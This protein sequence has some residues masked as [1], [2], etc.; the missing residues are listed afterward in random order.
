MKLKNLI[1]VAFTAAMA[2]WVTSC[3]ETDS[4]EVNVAIAEAISYE[5]NGCSTA[6]FTVNVT[7]ADGANVGNYVVGVINLDDYINDDA[8]FSSAIISQIE[9]MGGSLTKVDNKYV[10]NSSATAN[11]ATA[12]PLTAGEDYVVGVFSVNSSGELNSEVLSTKVSVV[13][14]S[15]TIDVLSVGDVTCSVKIT[16]NNALVDHYYVAVGNSSILNDEYAGD[17][18]A[19]AEAFI[20]DEI[21]VYGTD[22]SIVD[23]MYVFNTNSIIAL[24]ES[25]I[26]TSATEHVV[27]AFGIDADGTI[28]SDVASTTFSTNEL[29]MSDNTFTFLVTDV[30]STGA[31]LQ[32]T[33]SNSDTYYFDPVES[34][35]FSSYTDAEII[36]LI[37][38]S[39]GVYFSDFLSSGWDAFDYTG[40]L[41]SNTYYTPIAFGTNG[42]AAT[43]ELFK[44]EQFYTV[45]SEDDTTP[46]ILPT[47][48]T[49]PDVDFGTLELVAND[50]GSLTMTV[51]PNDKE[52]DYIAFV[53]YSLYFAEFDSYESVILDDL[54]YMQSYSEYYGGDIFEDWEFWTRSGDFTGEVTGFE[55]GYE[56]VGYAY[57][58]DKETLQPLTN[59][60]TVTCTYPSSVAAKSASAQAADV[61]SRI[62]RVDLPKSTK[63]SYRPLVLLESKNLPKSTLR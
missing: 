41:S 61:A 16:K 38:S 29:Q 44:G 42:S 39:A 45:G 62:V 20:A 22:L 13:G 27:L 8:I 25:W 18:L 2:I 1:L 32:V 58:I 56:C 54:N 35:M 15:F 40:Y 5:V 36:S 10:F 52:M 31:Y 19:Y 43:T 51:T 12:W 3:S 55:A 63:D 17:T 7:I 11:I 37:I 28:T 9:S 23:E 47:E 21:N 48:I 53:A 49:I 60:T 14:N 34:A 4:S 26:L 24:N 30:N 33:P 6:D 57:G 50:S 46:S 59:I